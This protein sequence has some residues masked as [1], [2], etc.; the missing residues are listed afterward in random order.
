MSSPN[1][2]PTSVVS[3]PRPHSTSHGF[4]VL[5]LT[6]CS[7]APVLNS[8]GPRTNAEACSLGLRRLGADGPRHLGPYHPESLSGLD[9]GS[10]IGVDP[11]VGTSGGDGQVHGE[12][13]AGVSDADG[14]CLTKGGVTHV[15][16]APDIRAVANPPGT[17]PVTR[18]KSSISTTR[19]VGGGFVFAFDAADL[20]ENID[21]ELAVGLSSTSSPKTPSSRSAVSRPSP[22]SEVTG[23]SPTTTLMLGPRS[24]RNLNSDSPHGLHRGEPSCHG[25]GD[26]RLVPP[27]ARPRPTDARSRSRRIWPQTVH[28]RGHL[29]IRGF[30]DPTP[31]SFGL[32]GADRRNSVASRRNAIRRM[33][34]LK[35]PM[36]SQ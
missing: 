16:I 30:H 17:H 32:P 5:L 24:P 27:K 3:T 25:N 22:Q 14:P 6:P 31:P 34:E 20:T 7:L 36:S 33:R 12:D 18:T 21:Q 2:S 35:G 26:G 15:D 1:Q 23:S 19:S 4:D 9:A 8:R 29:R 28:S 10:E 11:V 13:A